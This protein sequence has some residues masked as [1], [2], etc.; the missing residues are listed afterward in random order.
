VSVSVT[1][2]KARAQD[3]LARLVAGR[4]VIPAGGTWGGD[5]SCSSRGRACTSRPPASPTAAASTGQRS[6]PNTARP[7]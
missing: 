5:A 7:R 4:P 1:F 2:D 3:I 6:T